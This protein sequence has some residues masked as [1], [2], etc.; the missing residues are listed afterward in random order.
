[1]SRL[2][3]LRRILL[4]G[5]FFLW[6]PAGAAD[7][8]QL[9]RIELL[10][11][12]APVM[13]HVLM[14]EGLDI[15]EGSV[16]QNRMELVVNQEE[17]DYLND[18][19]FQTKILEVSRPMN[20]IIRERAGGGI[21]DYPDLAAVL[22]HMNSVAA[23]HPEICTVVNLTAEYGTPTFEGRDIFAVKISDNVNTDEDEPV[24]MVVSNYHA[25]EIVTPVIA[26]HAIDQ[27]VN[28]YGVDAAVTEAVNQNEIWIAPTFNP[29]GYNHVFTVA[30]MWR[31]NRRVFGGGVGVDLNRNHAMG[32]GSSC[33]GSTFVSSDTYRGPEIDSEPETQT[34]VNMSHDRGFAR[35]MDYHSS[36]RE[37]LWSYAISCNLHPFDDWLED[38]ARDLSI[39]SG[40]GGDRRYPSANGE[41]YEWQLQEMGAF[42]FLVETHT[43][44]QPS[45][46][47]AQAEAQT[48]WPGILWML[49]QPIPV[50]GHVTDA[51]SGAPLVSEITF[52]GVN[53][54]NGEKFASNPRFGR[55]HVWAPP[56]Q[57]QLRFSADGYDDQVHPV[58]IAAQTGLE[59]EVQLSPETTCRGDL[60]T[61]LTV[62]IL[63]MV[64]VISDLGSGSGP[65]DIN[66]DGQV[67]LA[68]ALL[69]AGIWGGCLP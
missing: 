40:Y 53:F 2:V 66:G 41:H 65:T 34:M 68:D 5:S 26:L 3:F 44:F 35:V 14:E 51:D 38:M 61:D 42:A 37:A 27:F 52:E 58:T 50:S 19:A 62:N 20:E 59:L 30:N 17:L 12:D 39:A 33:G 55:Y 69:L 25:R 9:F 36:G 15:L 45:Y 63:D 56:G 60:N 18:L 24:M 1:M 28:L 16:S 13:E 21:P 43:T 22:A 49:A 4:I 48:V 23:D 67:T 31:K 32:W 47:S 7:Q 6:L 29:D 46:A 57:Y 11:E 10:I 8:E 54:P 64:A